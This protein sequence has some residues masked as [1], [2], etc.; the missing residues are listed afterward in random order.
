[1]KQYVIDEL[2]PEDH[3]KIKEYLD[4]HYGPAE[5]GQ[6]YW[7]PLTAE[8]LNDIQKQH[9]DCQPFC[10]AIDLRE[11]QLAL[12]LLVRTKSQIRCACISY[13]DVH[14]RNWLLD[15]LDAIF[16]RLGVIT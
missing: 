15:Q 16:E 10:V 13:A 6:I 12:E 7:V 9:A 5:M 11:N 4:K 3:R 1:M 8:V 14:Q 2:R